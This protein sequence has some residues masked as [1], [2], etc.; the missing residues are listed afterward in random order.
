MGSI[1]A[2]TL[3]GCYVEYLSKVDCTGGGAHGN[4][5]HS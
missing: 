1:I 5:A 2:D 3:V 4:T